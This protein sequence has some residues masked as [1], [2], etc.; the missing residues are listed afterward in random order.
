MAAHSFRVGRAGD[1]PEQ[2]FRTIA[3]TQLV[4]T[5]NQVISMLSM[6]SPDPASVPAQID[7]IL[8]DQIGWMERTVKDAAD[9]KTAAERIGQKLGEGFDLG[10]DD[11]DAEIAS[12]DEGAD[13]DLAKLQASGEFTDG[14]RLNVRNALYFC[15]NALPDARRTTAEAAR[16]V[17]LAVSRQLAMVEDLRREILDG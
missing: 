5:I 6:G 3:P 12:D 9:S 14:A 15:W 13:T 7:Q 4:T 10:D 1:D 17:R 8:E 16:I 11:E 2:F